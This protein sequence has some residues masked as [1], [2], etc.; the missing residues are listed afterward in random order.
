MS[1]TS[2]RQQRQDERAEEAADLAKEQRAEDKAQAKADKKAAASQPEKVD[3][4]PVGLGGTGD[5]HV[6]DASKMGLGH[7]E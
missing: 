6:H 3:P 2:E 1:K 7:K 5:R 4:R